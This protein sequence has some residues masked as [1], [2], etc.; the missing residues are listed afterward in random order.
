MRLKQSE[1]TDYQKWLAKAVTILASVALAVTLFSN[2][3]LYDA[4]YKQESQRLVELVKSQAILI[5]AIA[6][7]DAEHSQR[8]HP[9]GAIG[10]TFSQLETAHRQYPGFGGTGEFTLGTRKDGNIIF[11]LSHRHFDFLEPL[12]I[13]WDSELGEPMRRALRG[14]NGVGVALDYRGATVL[15][16]YEPL[17]DLNAG[18]VAKIDLDEIRQPFVQA[19]LI[20][21]SGVL[22]MV[23]IGAMVFRRIS[24]PLLE[25]EQALNDLRLLSQAI[26]QSPI[27]MFITN[28]Q[29]VIEYVNPS[30]TAMTGYAQQEAIGQNPRILKSG[31]TSPEFYEQMWANLMAGQEWRGEVKDRRKDGSTFWA[32]MVLAPVK[33][34]DGKATHFVAIH[35]DITEQKQAQEAMQKAREQ[36]DITNR[37]KSEI[38]ANMSHELRT[39]LNAIIGFSSSMDEAIFG[40]LGHDKYKEYAQH[41]HSSGAHLLEIIN[42]ILDVAA[43]EAGKLKLN[44]ERVNV[45]EVIEVALRMISPKAKEGGVHLKGPSVSA[46]PPLLADPRRLKQIALNILSNAVKFTPKDG[47]VTCDVGI[48]GNGAMLLTVTDTGVGMDEAEIVKAMTQFGQVDSSLARKHEGTGLGLPLTQGLVELHGGALSLTSQK[49]VG[50]QVTVRFPAERVIFDGAKGLVDA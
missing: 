28:T 37:A 9:Q 2:G 3:L 29:G 45:Q 17:P 5:N 41:I 42:D 26:N 4:A 24:I 1:K 46:L 39:P 43:V 33:G 48:D 31:E 15:A 19:A 14:E 6:K 13:A 12:P 36:S 44:E 27:M 23:V 16:A 8:D 21:L 7:F 47:V 32:S 30:F 35:E 49:G 50:T 40:P 25:R 18:I 22:L 20:G 38:M 34:E 11:L 10:A